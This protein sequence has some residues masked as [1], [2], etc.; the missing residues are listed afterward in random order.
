MK[1]NNEKNEE[2]PEKN[3][4]FNPRLFKV[5]NNHDELDDAKQTL[6]MIEESGD[7]NWEA[8]QLFEIGRIYQARGSFSD[9]LENFEKANLIFEQVRNLEWKTSTLNSISRI[10][11][12][13]KQYSE[14]LI[15]L[16]EAVK[17]LE[18]LGLSGSPQ[19]IDMRKAYE[20]IKV[21]VEQNADV[22]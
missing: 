16:E 2:H 19:G 4:E 7:K 18:N 17:I 9:A 20:M 21:L 10:L 12:Q 11:Y 6:K 13:Q 14:A 1:S 15:R 22:V 3:K 5:E 8:K